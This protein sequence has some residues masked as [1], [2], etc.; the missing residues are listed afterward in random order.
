MKKQIFI[1]V[2]LVLVTFASVTTS[3]GQ[4]G[5][6]A[7]PAAGA[8][9]A[10]K[11]ITA[12]CST[13]DGLAPIAGK[14]YTYTV[15][16]PTPTGTKKYHWLVTKSKTFI[17]T[18]SFAP[19]AEAKAGGVI[20]DYGTGYNALT[21]DQ[22]AIDVTWDYFVHDADN[23]VFLVVYVTNTDA[24]TCNTNNV[25]VYI[26]KPAH[27]FTL[28]IANLKSDGAALG[29][30]GNGPCAANVASAVYDVAT[31]K[32]LMN[33][34]VN[35]LFFSV[36]AANFKDSWL[37]SFQVSGAV[38]STAGNRSVTAIDW[39]YPAAATTATGWKSTTITNAADVYTGTSAVANP[40]SAS[41]AGATVGATGETIIVRVTVDNGR[42]ETITAEAITLAVDGIMRDHTKS[43]APFYETVA[44]GDIHDAA[45]TVL[46]D[47]CPWI[48]GFVNDKVTQ[49]II[50]RPNINE[51]TPATP[52]FVPKN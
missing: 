32:V 49:N 15:Q 38:S 11:T 39:Q 27:S 5:L 6:G 29:A 14:S 3:Y 17:A 41:T 16:V 13:T 45:S 34:G 20:L 24:A 10:A 23:P 48:D 33:Y 50:P 42:M 7:A 37:P 51:V 4:I 25:E 22:A 12:T 43:V 30:G 2:I 28:D 8:L 35:Y 44:M 46:T 19:T 40:V 31:S 52:A 47:P 1:L 18:G 9:A 36:T 26:I 21:T